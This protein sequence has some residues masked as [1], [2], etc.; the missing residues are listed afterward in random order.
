MNEKRLSLEELFLDS[1][2]GGGVVEPSIEHGFQLFI[3]PA[4]RVAD[5]DHVGRRL[6]IHRIEAER[7][8]DTQLVQL[9]GHGRIDAL[10][11]AGDPV[12]FRL[13][14]AGQGSHGGAGDSDQVI[15]HQP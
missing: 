14:Q 12:P 5:H 6:E 1:V 2:R 13:Q 8:L 11:R 15:V 7:V 3:A 4:D 10:I 9:G